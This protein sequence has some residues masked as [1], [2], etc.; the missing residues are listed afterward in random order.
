MARWEVIVGPIIFVV[1]VTIIAASGMY[2]LI[3][4][5]KTLP[6]PKFSF[7]DRYE[8]DAAANTAVV[9][10]AQRTQKRGSGPRHRRTRRR[11]TRRSRRHKGF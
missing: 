9:V 8:A 5:Y 6:I 2:F 7:T 4:R 11:H 1:L 3:K 10:T